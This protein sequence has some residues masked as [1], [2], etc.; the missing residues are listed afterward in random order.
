[1]TNLI[2]LDPNFR[3]LLP[4]GATGGNGELEY[5]NSYRVA[6][7]LAGATTGVRVVV[8]DAQQPRLGK[9][10]PLSGQGDVLLLGA[11]L[12][13]PVPPYV[14]V[15]IYPAGGTAGRGEPI[16]L[17]GRPHEH[18]P[19]SGVWDFHDLDED[20]NGPTVA[21]REEKLSLS[22]ATARADAAAGRVMTAQL[23]LRKEKETV[24]G[25][26][27]EQIAR[28]DKGLADTAQ[29]RLRLDADLG[30][31]PRLARLPLVTADNL[32][33]AVELPG[34]D[35]GSYMALGWF[36]GDV[37]ACDG[38]RLRLTAYDPTLP[39]TV[40][41]VVL[42]AGDSTGAVLAEATVSSPLIPNQQQDVDF[43]FPAPLP[44]TPAVWVDLIADGRISATVRNVAI[45]ESPRTC[46]SG[47]IRPDGLPDWIQLGLQ[48]T[49]VT[50]W[51][52]LVGPVLQSDAAFSDALAG[53]AAKAVAPALTITPAWEP[54][55]TLPAGGQGY[56]ES[57]YI[58][59]GWDAGGVSGLV[60]TVQVLATAVDFK[61]VTE[62]RLVLRENGPAGP[63]IA[64]VTQACRLETS[65]EVPLAMFF[66]AVQTQARVWVEM[67]F[68]A[69][70]ML[71]RAVDNLPSPPAFRT[72]YAVSNAYSTYAA[73]GWTE[74]YYHTTYATTFGR[75]TGGTNLALAPALKSTM[76]QTA[77]EN[78]NPA[79]VA[80]LPP[81]V[82]AVVGQELVIQY[83]NVLML[84]SNRAA[85]NIR[86]FIPEGPDFTN[87]ALGEATRWR[88]T[89]P[90]PGD[91]PWLIQVFDEDNVLL[92][93]AYSTIR[94]VP[95]GDG[96]GV[97][98]QLLAIGESHT[99]A[100]A[101]LTPLP[102]LAQANGGLQFQFVGTRPTENS[103]LLAE[104]WPGRTTKW[105]T[106][107]PASPLVFNGKLD[108]A[109]YLS[110]GG[111]TL[112]TG[113]WV[114]WQFSTNALDSY[115]TMQQALDTELPLLEQVI[116]QFQ[117]A[118]PGVRFGV[119][120]VFP[121]GADPLFRRVSK[122]A[123]RYHR[124]LIDRFINR[125]SSGVYYVPFGL[126]ADRTYGFNRVSRSPAARLPNER[127]TVMPDPIHLSMIT[128]GGYWQ[129][130]D[131]LYS[132]LK[133]KG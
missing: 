27:D 84:G 127:E 44:A 82:Y 20:P 5:A 69:P 120:G 110:A 68:N 123:M 121:V 38:L 22:A 53:A 124:G 112:G 75:Q 25:F 41:R 91:R 94:V 109:H 18:P 50:R 32:T 129:E 74:L 115:P 17:S 103:G 23:D 26:V 62:V 71:R 126:S 72:R 16:L 13:D 111:I 116:A 81:V 8:P 73:P 52:R 85:Y 48:V 95:A 7:L 108:I 79:P 33:G 78:R 83:D 55:L 60:D 128:N 61:P 104:G 4:E 58:A 100:G 107:D 63:I 67:A 96:A 101:Y 70:T 14:T 59:W 56:G 42:R 35:N 19:G 86:G 76:R 131:N 34:F 87:P 30:R 15:R 125:E 114:L 118:V 77:A 51:L 54:V 99:H 80:V 12:G 132:F 31:L 47:I 89:P 57:A 64:N 133:A 113:D 49:F 3:V 46:F 98:R 1:M 97:T 65:Q 37:L 36:V 130:A 45:A 24:A 93:N 102:K 66:P 117:A 9:I 39:P 119:L 11:T 92:L 29:T 122:Q 88:W 28:V 43:L 90:S 105:A 2:K 6:A 106:T 40:L 10:V 21:S